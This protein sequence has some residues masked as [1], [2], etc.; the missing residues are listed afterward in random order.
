MIAPRWRKVLRDLW[1]NRMRTLLVVLSIAVGVAALGIVGATYVIVVRDLPASYRT[2]NPASARIFADPFNDELVQVVRKLPGIADAEGRR[3][4]AARL[5]LDGVAGQDV[6]WR[7]ISLQAIPDFD[8]IRINQIWPERGAWP[9][10]P[11][12]LLI[13]R[14]ALALTGAAVGDTVVIRLPND[15]ERELRIT[16]LVHD[17]TQPPARFVN[18]IYGYIN[19]ETLAWLGMTQDYSEIQIVVAENATDRAHVLDVA[20]QVRAK[21]E[22]SGRTVYYT[23]VAEPGKHPFERFINP[24][25]FLLSALGILALVL[26]GFLVVNTISALLAQQL[27]Q[28]GVMKAIGARTSQIAGLY[29]GMVAALGALALL[30]ALPLGLLGARVIT[31]FIAGLIN[32]D[33]A[34]FRAPGWVFALQAAAA[35]AAPILAALAPIRSGTRITVREAITS[36]GLSVGHFGQGR[37]DRWLA[38]VKGLSRPFLLSLRNTF[39][40]KGRLALTLITLGLGSTIFVAVFSVRASLLLTLDDALKYWQYDVGIV[41]DRSYRS[42]EIQRAA[43]AV[44]GVTQAESWGYDS[45]R[46]RRPDG[47]ESDNL[48]LIAPPAETT[49]LQPDIWRGRWLL[50]EDES[51]VVINTDLLTDEPDIRIGQQL[52]LVLAGRETTWTVVGIIRGVL[53]GPTVYANYS[54]YTRIARNVDRAGSVQIVTERH[55]PAF[56][57]QVAKALEQQFERSSLRVS[58]TQT[59]AQLRTVTTN[60]YN[61]ILVFLLLMAVLLAVV[62]ALGLA[63]TMSINVL[64][65]TREIGVMRAVGATGRAV[66]RIVIGEGVLIGVL[67]W[68]VG[69]VLAVPVSRFLS[70]AVGI[71]FLRAPL[72]Y[73]FSLTGAGVWLIIV[74]LL[75]ALASLLPARN[76]SRLSVR[77]VLAYE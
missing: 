46:R 21:V 14:A 5:R 7:D 20:A 35:L 33:V 55:T 30:I 52:T 10:G 49:L 65:R 61:V 28:I 39:R 23:Q 54:Y 27:R 25:A 62:G 63:G 66:R 42:E 1:G 60:Q 77:E 38:G 76:A 44:P 69:A 37:I 47:T 71:S 73:T 43:L 9:P 67:S 74:M 3:T 58:T 4:I 2:A 13:E 64:E 26:S 32:F 12:E 8:R 24:M 16:G 41:F 34:S 36:Y 57:S 53:A 50:P 70:S 19:Q 11:R 48:A 6:Q 51:A 15:V 68:L 31:G 75:A 45:V 72:S 56:Q 17:L 22:N 59:I 29:I 40:R 18:R